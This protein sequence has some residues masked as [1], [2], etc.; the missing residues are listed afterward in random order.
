[1]ISRTQGRVLD[2]EDE[3]DRPYDSMVDVLGGGA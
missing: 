1:M 3:H 2:V